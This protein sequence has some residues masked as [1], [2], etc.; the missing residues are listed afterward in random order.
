[1][2][3]WTALVI[4]LLMFVAGV[5]M[6]RRVTPVRNNDDADVEEAATIMAMLGVII[7]SVSIFLLVK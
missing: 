1:M 7:M 3:I 2:M 5:V 6:I 4:G